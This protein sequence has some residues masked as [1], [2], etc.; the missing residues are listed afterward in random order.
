TPANRYPDATA[1]ALRERLA[2]RHRVDVDAVHVAAGSV[3]I[4]YQLVAAVAAAGDEVIDAWRSFEAYPGIPLIS[5]AVGVPVPLV[6]G[7]GEHDLGAMAE[8]VTDRTR[9]I[10]VCT[11]N[12]P[13]GP[14]ISAVEFAG[15]VSRVPAD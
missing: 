8:A 3:S 1:Q 11:P 5:G 13:T 9:A 15:F 10:I 2:E 7:T 6:A 12:N 4:L 14:A